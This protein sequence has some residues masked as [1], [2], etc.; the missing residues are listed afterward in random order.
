MTAGQG[1]ELV[2]AVWI[3]VRP[4]KVVDLWEKVKVGS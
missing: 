1:S 2:Q 3:S 4:P